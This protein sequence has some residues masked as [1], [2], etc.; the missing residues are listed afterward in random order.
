MATIKDIAKLA[1]VSQGTVSNVLNGKGIV[2]SKK[3]LLVEEAART[4]GYTINQKAKLLRK[5]SSKTIALILPT[6]GTSNTSTSKPHSPPLPK[7]MDLKSSPIS[8]TTTK[9][10]NATSSN[11]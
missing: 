7:F 8:P 1:G 10:A 6:A 3:I 9:N 2:S 5:G 4:L 11:K